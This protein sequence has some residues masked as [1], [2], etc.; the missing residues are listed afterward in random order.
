M[1]FMKPHTLDNKVHCNMENPETHAYRSTKID[2]TPENSADES[3]SKRYTHLWQVCIQMHKV[4]EE[5]L[6]TSRK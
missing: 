5:I 3:D 2:K 1:H 6:E 4:L